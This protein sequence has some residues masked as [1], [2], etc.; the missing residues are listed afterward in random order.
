VSA[1]IGFLIIGAAKAGTTSLFEYLRTHPQVHMPREKE[2]YFFNVDRNYSRGLPWYE[3]TVTRGAAPGSVCGEATVEYLS[4]GSE[5]IPRRIR[6]ALPDVRLV[7]VLRDPVKRAQSHHRMMTLNGIERRSFACAVDELIGA[8]ALAAARVSRS[9]TSGY[10]VDGEYARLLSAYLRVFEPGQLEVVFSDELTADPAR[11]LARLFAFIGVD[12][13]HVPPNI[14]ERYREAALR[15]RIAGLNLVNWQHALAR[16]GPAR[17]AWHRLPDRPRHAVDRVY[18]VA[19]HRVELWNARRGG[20][21][22]QI[23]EPLQRQL[24]AHYERDGEMLAELIGR[25]PPWLQQWQAR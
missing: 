12:P 8:D 17:A 15:P 1:R 11:T 25:Q 24:A 13:G 4:G 6:R 2:I 9:R 10:L 3:E 18:N 21:A 5:L 20:L 22:E 14:R 19:N 23:D 16:V 7:C